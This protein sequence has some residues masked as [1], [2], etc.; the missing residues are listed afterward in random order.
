LGNF[1]LYYTALNFVEIQPGKVRNAKVKEKKKATK[2][3]EAS[4]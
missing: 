3:R 4:A 2:A 1:S